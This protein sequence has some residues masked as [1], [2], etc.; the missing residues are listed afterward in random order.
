MLILLADAYS[1]NRF[2]NESTSTVANHLRATTWLSTTVPTL[3]M[4]LERVPERQLCTPPL[5]G[6]KGSGTMR[7]FLLLQVTDTRFGELV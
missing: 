1:R 4:R 6:K 5:E 7:F 2:C 3:T